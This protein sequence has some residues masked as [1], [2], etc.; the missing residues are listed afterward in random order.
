MTSPHAC[1][2]LTPATVESSA[3]KLN[4]RFATHGDTKRIKKKTA[5]HRKE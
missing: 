1:V 2:Q 3:K 4:E 5:K